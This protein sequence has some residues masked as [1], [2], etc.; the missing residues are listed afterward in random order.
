MTRPPVAAPARRSDNQQDKVYNKADSIVELR[1]GAG[2]RDAALARICGFAATLPGRNLSAH[3]RAVLEN[4]CAQLL[5][6]DDDHGDGFFLRPHVVEELA[7][8]A[9]AD[10]PRYLFYRFRY[11]TFPLNRQTD[12]YPPCVQ[13]EPTSICNYRCVFCYQTDPG[14]TQGRHGHMG[15]MPLDLFRRIIDEIEGEVEAVTLASRGEPLMARDILPMLAYVGGKF[16]GLKINTNAAFLDEARAHALLQ[17]NPNTIVFSADAA[18]PE[19]YARLRVNGNLETVARNIERFAD[20]RARHYPDNRT[21]LRVSGVR[22]ADSQNID[23]NDLFW[24]RFVDQVALVDYIPWENAYDA[25]PNGRSEACSDLW[26]RLFVWWDGRM[27]PC[28]VD[29]KSTL[30]VGRFP[31]AGISRTWTGPAY[32]ALRHAHLTGGRQTQTP[33]RGCALS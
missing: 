2:D 32:T 20:I 3:R 21:I 12:A 22:F 27:N 1:G 29:Y 11:E 6:T 33:C 31:E 24:R 16:L 4:A 7:R 18:E 30:S 10:L 14:L 15:M 26:R 19:L 13:I 17:A 5:S 9:D 25:P 28:D 23:A 8:V